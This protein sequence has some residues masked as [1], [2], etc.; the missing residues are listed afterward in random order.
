MRLVKTEH[1]F[2]VPPHWAHERN[3]LC[4]PPRSWQFAKGSGHGSGVVCYMAAWGYTAAPRSEEGQPS[5]R[6]QPALMLARVA[7]MPR[8]FPPTPQVA[9]TD[10]Q[11]H[12]RPLLL[13]AQANTVRISSYA[14]TGSQAQSMPAA[15]GGTRN[16]QHITLSG[17]SGAPA[18][19][20]LRPA[21]RFLYEQN[22]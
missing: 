16:R 13:P 5:N 17:A 4:G 6:Q 11:C 21:T 14:T 7:K 10:L 8:S 12:R 15:K 20:H 1:Q 22:E 2:Q 9:P 18:A 3:S 19:T